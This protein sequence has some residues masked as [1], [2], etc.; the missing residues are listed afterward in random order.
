MAIYFSILGWKSPWREEPGRLQ[1]TEWQKE[2]DTTKCPRTHTR[3]QCSTGVNA[4]GSL[5]GELPC[6]RGVAEAVDRLTIPSSLPHFSSLRLIPVNGMWV[7]LRIEGSISYT[8]SSG[9]I[10]NSFQRIRHLG[11]IL[12]KVV[13]DCT[14]KLWSSEITPQT[15]HC[16][17]IALPHLQSG[18][19]LLKP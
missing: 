5:S 6:M 17:P 11:R 2:L 12:T 8:P 19:K 14:L 15:L 13:K 16:I 7:E 3:V 10:Y 1:S 4:F 18:A 9:P